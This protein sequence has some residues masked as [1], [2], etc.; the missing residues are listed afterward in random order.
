MASKDKET[1]VV[2]V[3]SVDTNGT[4]HNVMMFHLVLNNSLAGFH[5]YPFFKRQPQKE[6]FRL[7][8]NKT[9]IDSLKGLE[10]ALRRSNKL[11]LDARNQM[12]E[13]SNN[14]RQIVSLF[15]SLY[16]SI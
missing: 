15:R 11:E 1:E 7:D 3:A 5:Y 16:F 14:I 9:C 8:K 12:L 13:I 6:R 10:K 2:C 4:A